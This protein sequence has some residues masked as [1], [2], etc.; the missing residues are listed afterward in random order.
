M[1][2]P[3]EEEANDQPFRMLGDLSSM[4]STAYRE[5]TVSDDGVFSQDVKYDPAFFELKIP[6]GYKGADL[7]L[8]QFATQPNPE[9]R[10]E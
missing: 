8:W 3:H 4:V 7:P 1:S 9:F 10:D 5:L 2:A 6:H